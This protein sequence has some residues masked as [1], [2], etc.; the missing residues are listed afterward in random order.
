[1]AAPS[2]YELLTWPI[3][4]KPD[5]ITTAIYTKLNELAARHGLKVYDFVATFRSGPGDKDALLFEDHPRDDTLKL[6]GY[7][8][9]VRALGIPNDS[10]ALIG[11][12]EQIIDALDSALQRAP[13]P[14]ARF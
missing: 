12:A 1:M 2:D 8:K 3:H 13:R 11:S 7:D 5:N 6:K 4:D 10:A 9:M 14:P